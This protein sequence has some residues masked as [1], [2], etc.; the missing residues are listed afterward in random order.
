MNTKFENLMECV[1]CFMQRKDERPWEWP[2]AQLRLESMVIG[3]SHDTPE[4]VASLRKALQLAA[5]FNK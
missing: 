4:E 5:E 1:R 2:D 3:A